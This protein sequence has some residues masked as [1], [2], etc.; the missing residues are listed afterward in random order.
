MGRYKKYLTI[1]LMFSIHMMPFN[2]VRASTAAADGWSITKRIVQGATTFYDGTKNVVLNGKNYAAK[3]TAAITPTASQVSKMIVRTGAVLAVDLAIKALLGGVDY[4]MDSANNRVKYQAPGEIGVWMVVGVTYENMT[5]DQACA[6]ARSSYIRHDSSFCYYGTVDPDT[7]EENLQATWGYA[8]VSSTTKEEKYLPYDAVAAQIIGDAAGKD[9]AKAYVS[10]VADTASEADPQRQIIPI[11]EIVNQ[12]NQSQSISTSNT[13]TGS[14]T[15]TTST[16]T[17]TGDPTT[18]APTDIALNFPE[19]CGWAPTVCQAAQA[20]I[21]FPKTASD[22]W[23]TGSKAASQTLQDIKDWV[24]DPE[25]TD[26]TLDL[27]DQTQPEPNTQ[28]SFS[29]S[30]PSKIPLTFSW[31]GQTLDF[32]FDFT[33]WCN[34]ISTFVYPIVVALGALHALYIVSGVREDG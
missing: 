23:D 32:S 15:P 11:S 6:A 3:G 1:L 31:N 8:L 22:W 9:D 21:D 16:G 17:G 27:D 2:A 28:I 4:V 25:E 14:A 26:N 29:T 19:F 18:S 13:A 7:G 10:S 20:A 12:L 33:I 5:I 24:K 30:C 34:A